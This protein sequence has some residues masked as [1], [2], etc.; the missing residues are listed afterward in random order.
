MQRGQTD[1]EY[2]TLSHI[3]ELVDKGKELTTQFLH[4]SRNTRSV[5]LPLNLNDKIREFSKFLRRTIPK[6]IGLEHEL[7]DDLTAID[8]DESQ[9]DLLLM[10]FGLNAM[11]TMPDGGRLRFRT[12]NTTVHEGHP[13]RGGAI[14]PGEYVLLT[15]CVTGQGC[16]LRDPDSVYGKFI[17]IDGETPARGLRLSAIYLIVKN[18][19]GFVDV[20][21]VT[22]EGNRLD[23][24]FPSSFW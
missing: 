4:V 24:Y 13:L 6:M 23:L 21:D 3:E 1:P 16:S 20:P 15:V 14:P 5:Y 7:A 22:D 19:G 12:A 17:G 2:E 11:D 8:A 10:D 18:H 9:I